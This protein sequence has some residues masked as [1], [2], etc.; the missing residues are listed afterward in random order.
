MEKIEVFHNQLSYDASVDFLNSS[1][2]MQRYNFY[3]SKVYPFQYATKKETDTH[4]YWSYTEMKPRFENNRLFYSRNNK[5]GAT[6]EKKTNKFKIWFGTPV[7][8]IPSFIIDSIV[9]HFQIDWFICLPN[10]LTSLLNATMLAGM[11]KGKITNPRDYIKAY[12]K[13]SP[14]KKQDVSIELFYKTFGGGN[15]NSPKFFR[16][17][18]EYSTNIN[19]AL[20]LITKMHYPPHYVNDLYDQ[21]AVLNR[22]VNPRWSQKR[23]DLIHSQW[24]REI[25]E[26]EIKSIKAHDYKYSPTNLPTGI[27]LITDNY[28]LF[29]EGSIMKHCVYT[30]Y[31]SKIRRR[32]YFAFRYDREGVRAT[33][34]IR[35][36][37]A[38]EKC[39]LDQMYG[40]GNSPISEEH[41]EIVKQ[42][43]EIDYVQEWFGDQMMNVQSRE[44]E[45]ID[46]MYP[47]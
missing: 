39:V 43:L 29:E 25:M 8:T 30:N 21:A 15:I 17:I 9:T 20:E 3:R 7:Y 6:Y 38:T 26:I 19:H 37:H 41:K 1:P 47:W 12:L 44:P 14:Y 18:L 42:W 45:P 4:V 5:Y 33:V 11:I 46:E 34:G 23:M 16:K 31:E 32:E 2:E 24:T 10:S 40:I 27:S 35:R 36:N 28:M 22:K 13:T